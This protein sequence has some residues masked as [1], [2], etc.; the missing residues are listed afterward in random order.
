MA[1]SQGLAAVGGGRARAAVRVA[2]PVQRKRHAGAMHRTA[3]RA[4]P[5]LSGGELM[6]LGKL[7]LTFGAL[8]AIP[9]WELWCLR[10]PRRDD[11]RGAGPRPAAQD[12][13]VGS[14]PDQSEH[15]R[16]ARTVQT[17]GARSS[18]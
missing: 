2:R 18:P 14:P 8:L 11:R 13:A 3:P 1:A 17:Q 4:R 16:R 15:A 9:A 5:P 12:Q 10:E 7:L 6:I